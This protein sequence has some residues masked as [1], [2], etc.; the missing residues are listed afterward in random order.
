MINKLGVKVLDKVLNKVLA[1]VLAEDQKIPRYQT[2]L[3][4]KSIHIWRRAKDDCCHAW[5]AKKR[6]KKK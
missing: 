3:W 5:S 1:K 2:D 6:R 4:G